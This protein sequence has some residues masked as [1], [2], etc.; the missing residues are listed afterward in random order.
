[1]V[2]PAIFYPITPFLLS[3]A[4]F[5]KNAFLGA[6]PVFTHNDPADWRGTASEYHAR[7][8]VPVRFRYFLALGI[9]FTFA[10]NGSV[11]AR[12][13]VTTI[14]KTR[15]AIGG[16]QTERR[17]GRRDPGNWGLSRRAGTDRGL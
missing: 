11:P 12:G 15:R 3:L 6:K 10:R 17:T 9:T 5:R 4:S 13:R 14:Y 8:Q 16:R 7:G 2:H 1:M